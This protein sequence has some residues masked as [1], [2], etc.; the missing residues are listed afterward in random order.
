[1][2][3]V[4]VTGAN[5]FVGQTLCRT[6][7]AAG[8]AVRAAVRGGGVAT[9]SGAESAAVGDIGSNTDWSG[10]LKGVE[11]VVHL[12]ARAHVLG[13]SPANADAYF[14]T[15]ERGTGCLAGAAARAG[16]R[17]LVFLSTV[18]V[19]GEE[20]SGAP[21][22]ASDTPNP[23]DAYGLS[24]WM[25]EKR[26][27][28]VAADTGMEVVVV[29]S[30]LVYGPGVRANFLRLMRLVD[31]QVPLPLGAIH[32]RRSLV[33]VWS[34]CDL[35]GN[36][37]ANPVASGRTWMVSDG[38]DLSTAD[39]IRRI[40]IVMQRRVRL[41]PVPVGLLMLGGRLLGRRAE[42]MRLCGSLA[43]DIRP[44]REYLGWSPP[45]SVNEGIARTVAWY[46]S[47]E[48]QLAH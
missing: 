3:R 38:E 16:V 40:A 12:A 27:R 36:V 30:P 8:F 11:S 41:L 35:L 2:R 31:R 47:Q 43:V 19:N 9:P 28:E 10:A 23:E 46:L 26:L 20:S 1:M 37:L 22:S 34:L 7:A 39:L 15:N 29:R 48:R 45:V 21:Y 44:T 33:S 42:V 25:A 13:D 17:R 14:E 32:N 18:K 24:K 5:G 6:L 4:L